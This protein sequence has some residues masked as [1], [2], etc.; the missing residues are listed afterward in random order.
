[1]LRAEN[2][3]PPSNSGFVVQVLGDHVATAESYRK[4]SELMLRRRLVEPA[5]AFARRAVEMLGRLGADTTQAELTAAR[6]ICRLQRSTPSDNP[7]PATGASVKP[8]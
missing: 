8:V 6:A 3:S 1:M 7:A 4:L 5:L 2:G